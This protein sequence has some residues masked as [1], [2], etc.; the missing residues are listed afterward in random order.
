[1]QHLRKKLQ[2]LFLA[3]LFVLVTI[4]VLFYISSEIERR[5]EILTKNMQLIADEQ[6]FETQYT[7]SQD[8][9][10]ATVD[11]RAELERYIVADN[12]ATIELLSQLD[13]IGSRQ[14]VELTTSNLE[15]QSTDG[16][17][18]ALLIRYN[19]SGRA[20]AVMHM[21]KIFET[22]PY[23][24]YVSSLSVARSYDSTIGEQTVRAEIELRLSI[25]KHD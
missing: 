22:L 9:V 19:I 6:S 17:F 8:M 13:E 23:H 20:D 10:L 14:G 2:P 24:G 5:G 21:I 25:K 1:M 11:E 3:I 12:R 4:T 18:N 15:E 7:V 16:T